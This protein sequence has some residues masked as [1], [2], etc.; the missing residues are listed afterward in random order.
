MR[1]TLSDLSL[2]LFAELERLG[3]E[4]LKGA[5]LTEEINRAQAVSKV[6][7]QIISNA[8]LVLR[9]KTAYEDPDNADKKPPKM[10]EG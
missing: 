9:V 3:D 7:S 6:A 4:D 5:E 8:S 2:H 10:L 1:N